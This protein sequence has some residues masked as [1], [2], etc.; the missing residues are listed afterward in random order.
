MADWYVKRRFG[1]LPREAARRWGDREALFFQGR[2]WSFRQLADDVDRAAK[3]LLAL[4]VEPGEHVGLWLGNRPEWVHL[5]FALARVGAVQ[6]PINTRLRSHEIGY[7][8]GQSRSRTLI[9]AEASGPANLLGIVAELLP[10]LAE[11]RPEALEVPDL[12]EFRRIV[13][14]GDCAQRGVLGW[15][16]LLDRGEAIPDAEL[17][18]RAAAVDPDGHLF[19]MY[20][21]GTTGFPKGVVHNH[22]I[23]RNV[24]DRGNRLGITQDDAVLMFLPLFHIFGFGDGPATTLIT[25]A[26]LVLTE[27]FDPDE[28]LDLVQHERPTVSHGFDTHFKDLLEAQAR[29]ARDLSSLRVVFAVAGMHSSTPIAR[30]VNKELCCSISG[31]GMTECYVGAALSFPSSTLEQRLEASGYPA[32]GYEIRVVDPE[33]GAD[34]PPDVPGEIWVR[35]YGVMEGYFDKPEETAKALDADGW[36]RTGDMG[37]LRADGH[38]R[39]IGR[40]KD[41]LKVGGE[42]VDPMEVESFLLE[43]PGV[44]QVAIV[45]Y[46]DERLG[47]VGVAFVQPQAE[48]RPQPDELI[49]YCKGRIAGFKVPRHV[50]FVEAFP[51]T[52]SGKV[53]KAKLRELALQQLQRDPPAS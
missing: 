5:M 13:A 38:L 3:G 30:R 36:L 25:G 32:P 22:N 1:D 51:M 52:S 35:G 15:D 23:I 18:R 16:D 2:R 29:Q 6:I 11:Q 42:N 21:S 45:G 37:L 9:T 12:P 53:Q 34:Q 10:G 39:F 47:E 8:L 49:A 41:M 17:E 4:G 33:T 26:R 7:V 48:P 20:T 46:P 14:V 27:G 24:E 50:L 44:H 19:I 31:F 28:C 43:H 40:Y